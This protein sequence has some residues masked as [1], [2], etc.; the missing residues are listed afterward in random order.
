LNSRE[1]VICAIN[2]EEPDRVPFDINPLHDFYLQLKTYLG[3]DI[4]EEVKHNFAMEVIPHHK[5]LETLGVDMIS[6]KLGS[7]VK[8]KSKPSADGYVEDD[9]GIRYKKVQQPGGGRYYEVIRSPLKNL[10]IDDLSNYP[11]PD[12]DLPGRGEKTEKTAKYLFENTELALKGRFGGAITEVALNML[13][14]EEWMIRLA[15][16]PEFIR[17]LLEKITDIQISLDRI[18][19][20]A[21]GK[22][23]QIFKASGEDLGMQTGPIYSK[24]MFQN[25]LLPHLK[26]RLL[27]ARKYLDE[28]NP[29]VKIMLH[30]CGSIRNFLPELIDA[31]VDIIDPVQPQAANMDT[32]ELKSEFG[33]KLSFH[34]GI[35]IQKVL[36]F[37]N[38]MDIENEAARRIQDLAPGGG[39]ILAPAHN[40]QADVPPANIVTLYKVSDRLG[41]YPLG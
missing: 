15:K 18:G 36:P 11:W 22:Y 17:A 6:V 29:S 27:A 23:L 39:Y 32:K 5:V 1:R 20:E 9:W 38:Q 16:D 34:G 33:E 41:R 21:A 28:V 2:H 35:D 26:R 25:Q 31:G 14:M 13:G 24:K 4:Q 19:L 8:K 12:V 40:V 37:G 7:P 10:Q 30:S 3:L